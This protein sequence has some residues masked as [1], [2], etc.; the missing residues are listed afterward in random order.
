MTELLVAGCYINTI[1][2][3]VPEL[4]YAI[5]CFSSFT[6]ISRVHIEGC[7]LYLSHLC[8]GPYKASWAN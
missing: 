8:V 4:L 2:E 6:T 3:N 1:K 5:F 7:N